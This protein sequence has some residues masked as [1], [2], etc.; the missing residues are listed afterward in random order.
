MQNALITA[1][2]AREIDVLTAHEAGT[3][4]WKDAEQLRFPTGMGRVLFTKH[5][6]DFTGLQ[7]E[8]MATGDHRAGIIVLNYQ[9]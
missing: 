5:V 6:G 8:V 9:R 2:R 3:R 7:S 4:H 1:L